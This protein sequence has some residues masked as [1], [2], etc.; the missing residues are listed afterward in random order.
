MAVEITLAQFNKIAIGDYNAGFVDFKT[1]WHGNV[2]NELRKVNNHVHRTG[3][4]TEEISPE[5]VLQVKEAFVDA[6]RRGNVPEASIKEI[7]RELGIP[8]E[9][10]VNTTQETLLTARFTPLTRT[11]TRY[12]LDKYAAGGIGFGENAVLTVSAKDFAKAAKTRNLSG[13]DKLTRMSVN[14][15]NIRKAFGRGDASGQSR[16]RDAP[17]PQVQLDGAARRRDG[18]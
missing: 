17:R 3:K 12:L 9:L 14:A 6:M 15:E 7:R 13:S 5:R 16:G 2:L 4:N 18:S 11:Q 1:D 8:A 10:D